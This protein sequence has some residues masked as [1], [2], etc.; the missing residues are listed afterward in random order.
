MEKG[1]VRERR[2]NG[3]KAKL[4]EYWDKRKGIKIHGNVEKR[5]KKARTLS[6]SD[7]IPEIVCAAEYKKWR[8]QNLQ[9]GG[10]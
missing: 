5:G 4:R 7:K 1:S 6:K 2:H 3:G 10:E 9:N 8:Q